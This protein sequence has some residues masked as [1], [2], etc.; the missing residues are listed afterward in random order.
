MSRWLY[1]HTIVYVSR[2]VRWRVGREAVP[3]RRHLRIKGAGDFVK[4]R[5]N[6]ERDHQQS[7]TSVSGPIQYVKIGQPQEPRE[8]NPAGTDK[9]QAS[10]GPDMGLCNTRFF[11]GR[12][13]ETLWIWRV[14]LETLS[15]CASMLRELPTHCMHNFVELY[16]LG[17]GL[18]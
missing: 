4:D 7:R 12:E 18:L 14:E 17:S 5:V 10:Y 1:G 6:L 13:S 11:W 9:D 3:K 16:K 2:R 8:S 15:V